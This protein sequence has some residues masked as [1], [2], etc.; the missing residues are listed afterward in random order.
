MDVQYAIAARDLDF[1]VG[2]DGMQHARFKV[3]ALAYDTSGDVLSSA[4]DDVSTHYSAAQMDQAKRVGV[5]MLQQVSV[6]K[7]AKFLLLTVIDLKTGRTG[8]IQ[9]ALESVHE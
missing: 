2:D 1:I 3:A 8:T 7:R 6:A 9:L 4:V 5:P